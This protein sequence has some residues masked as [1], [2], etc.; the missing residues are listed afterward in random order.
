MKEKWEFNW[1]KF[2]DDSLSLQLDE[3]KS[4]GWILDTINGFGYIFKRKIQ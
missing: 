4:N 3:M 1:I 2:T